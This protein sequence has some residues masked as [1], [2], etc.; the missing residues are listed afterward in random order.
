MASITDLL[1]SVGKRGT[2]TKL[3]AP[4]YSIGSTSLKIEDA[5]N[6]PTDSRVAFSMRKVYIG[7]ENNGKEV[8]GTYTEWT[9]IVNAEDGS[10]D[11]LQLQEGVD[12]DYLPGEETQV[13]IHVSVTAWKLLMQGLRKTLN[14][15]GTLK[16]SD[17]TVA[18]S[19]SGG[20]IP[21]GVTYTY[22]GTEE[23]FNAD[24]AAASWLMII[25]DREYSKTTYARLYAHLSAADADSVTDGATGNFKFADKWF[26]TV[27]VS[28][29][30]TQTEFNTLGKSSGAKSDSKSHDHAKGGSITTVNGTAGSYVVGTNNRTGSTSVTYSTLQPGLAINKLIKY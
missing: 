16:M 10:I 5:A 7:G 1:L 13:M 11:S 24:P 12:Q 28:L 4:G 6:W 20:I 21:V 30:A 14:L 15:D 29:D 22:Y 8:L 17:A 18:S 25:K 27:S 3:K 26:G 23:Q 9:G 2:L 19:V